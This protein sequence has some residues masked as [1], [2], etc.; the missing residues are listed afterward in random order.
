MGAISSILNASLNYDAVD[1]MSALTIIKAIRSGVNQGVFTKLA[2]QGQFSMS[3]WASYLH[4]SERTI[5]RLKK[6]SRPFDSPQSERIIQIMLIFRLGTDVFGTIDKFNAWLDTKSIALGKMK[7][8]ELLDSSFGIDL[9][10]DE[11]MR[12]EYGVLA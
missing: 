4:I 2:G 5:Q 3:E 10:K 7:P 6:E 12:I 8:K 11:L 1:D 9:V